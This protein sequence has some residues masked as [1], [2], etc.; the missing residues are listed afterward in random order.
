MG[1]K[2]FCASQYSKKNFIPIG[3][4]QTYP[5]FPPSAA[6]I[7]QIN[8]NHPKSLTEHFS[9]YHFSIQPNKFSHC[10]DGCSTF[11]QNITTFNQYMVQ[12]PPKKDHQL[13]YIF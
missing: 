5:F 13:N 11:L 8:S 1:V 9:T 3:S 10:E 7:C 2:T 12:K 6:V 4:G